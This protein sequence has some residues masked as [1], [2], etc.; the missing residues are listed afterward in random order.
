ML[1]ILLSCSPIKWLVDVSKLKLWI[2]HIRSTLTIRIRN[3]QNIWGKNVAT[4][5][6]TLIFSLV[7]SDATSIDGRDDDRSWLLTTRWC[8]ISSLERWSVV[9]CCRGEEMG[10]LLEWRQIMVWVAWG[11]EKAVDG[12]VSVAIAAKQSVRMRLYM[13][14][15]AATIAISRWWCR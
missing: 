11:G 15:A 4:L 2:A 12:F 6:A 8:T 10:L 7:S 5:N 3:N 13:F 14:V 1:I 9:G